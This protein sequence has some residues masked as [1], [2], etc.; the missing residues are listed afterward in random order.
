M[1]FDVIDLLIHEEHFWRGYDYHQPD[2]PDRVL[3]AVRWATDRGLKSV[4]FD[5][6]I[7]GNAS[8]E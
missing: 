4:Q 7:A 3:A 8:W 2:N 1:P 5:K 6:G